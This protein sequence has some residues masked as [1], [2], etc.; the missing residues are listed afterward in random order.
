MFG[1]TGSDTAWLVIAGI[2]AWT[3]LMCLKVVTF[4]IDYAVAMHRLATDVQALWQARLKRRMI[5]VAEEIGDLTSGRRLSLRKRKETMSDG[6]GADVT[7]VAEAD[8]VEGG[9]GQAVESK[10]A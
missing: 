9:E 8:V 4:N 2:A 6:G 7:A 5:P 10:A 1:A 3:V